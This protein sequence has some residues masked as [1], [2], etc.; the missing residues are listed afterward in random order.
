MTGAINFH[1]RPD[2]QYHPEDLPVAT[3]PGFEHERERRR[4]QVGQ[5]GVPDPWDTW[6]THGI[7]TGYRWVPTE[8]IGS[9]SLKCFSNSELSDTACDDAQVAQ[10][11]PR[12]M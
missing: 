9:A 1:S 6:D 3:M 12:G 8:V 11:S 10:A 5:G 7:P 2:S 4:R